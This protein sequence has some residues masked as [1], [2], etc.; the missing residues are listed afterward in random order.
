M[1]C[2]ARGLCDVLFVCDVSTSMIKLAGR[3]RF[4]EGQVAHLIILI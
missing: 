3:L 1:S 4:M 2:Q